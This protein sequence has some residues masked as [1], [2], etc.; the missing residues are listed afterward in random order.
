MLRHAALVI[1]V[2]VLPATAQVRN[3]VVDN[4][5]AILREFTELL[6]IPNI[7]SDA[8]NIRKNAAAIRSM[9]ERRGVRT[10]LLETAG[11]P[12]VIFGE[13]PAANAKRTVVFYAHYDG[14]PV[15]PT[16]WETGDPFKPV[17]KGDR[18]YGRSTS[19]DK[20]AIMAMAA[21]LDA[22]KSA[23]KAPNV[24]IKFFFEGEEEAGSRH[25]KTIVRENASLLR[26]DLWFICDGPVHQSGRQQVYFGARGVTGMEI[27]V[28]G[29]NR[30]L[31]SGHYGGWAPNPAVMLSHL[32]A[33]MRDENGRALIPGFYS[34][35]AR[36]S[37]AE[38]QALADTPA[39]DGALSEQFGLRRREN[40]E[41]KIEEIVNEP[42]LNVRGI[43]SADTGSQAR[44]VVP[45]LATAS[46]DIRLVK[47]ISPE[48]AQDRVIAHLRAKGYFVTEKDPDQGV[49]LAYP[50]VAKVTRS[51]GYAAAKTP[52]D[53]PIAQHAIK[54]IETVTGPVVKAPTLG[55][56]VPLY[57]FEQELRA[58][59]IGVPIANHDNNQHA[60]NENIRLA[61][62]WSGIQVMA[63][64]MTMD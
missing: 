14:Q 22:L 59:F 36:L 51:G 17:L 55:G 24:N 13:L 42:T 48:Q 54:A 25:L 60:A 38:K 10:R 21:A 40:S 7:A 19:D 8:H 37:A 6:S 20:A 23:G 52:M 27:T 43:R 41:R 46:I 34:D 33:S 45:A 31:H 28:Y 49:R 53:L 11:S 3:W 61:N 29:A 39:V 50:K 2:C 64:L 44:N 63:A 47:G 1:I 56:S 35:V 32:I 16:E 57:I 18:L 26:A 30:E 62:L 5:R 12:P 58:P 4:Q 15:N 9:F